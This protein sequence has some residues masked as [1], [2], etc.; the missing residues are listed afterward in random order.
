MSWKSISTVDSHA[1][2][3]TTAQKM[4]DS[5]SMTDIVRLYIFVLAFNGWQGRLSIRQGKHVQPVAYL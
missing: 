1:E 5:S 2:L 4:L 3:S